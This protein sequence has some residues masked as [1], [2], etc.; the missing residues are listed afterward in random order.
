MKLDKMGRDETRFRRKEILD[1]RGYEEWKN[2]DE[3]ERYKAIEEREQWKQY[4]KNYY[5]YNQNY[6]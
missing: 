6:Y 4:N 1:P 2:S 5:L 3:T